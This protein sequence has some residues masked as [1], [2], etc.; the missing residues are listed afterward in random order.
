MPIHTIVDT[1]PL[2]PKTRRDRMKARLRMAV[3]VAP[4]T[5]VLARQT[6]RLRMSRSQA[7]RENALRAVR[8]PI[9]AGSVFGRLV[10]KQR[11]VK[12]GVVN[13]SVRGQVQALFGNARQNAFLAAKRA[14]LGDRMEAMRHAKAAAKQ[15]A[16]GRRL[17][18]ELVR[19][20]A[21]QAKAEG[22][23]LIA[24]SAAMLE[25]SGRG[26]VAV[27]L[28]RAA[29]KL[30]ATP[31]AEPL[32]A[33]LAVPSRPERI[34]G[35]VNSFTPSAIGS[36][37]V[38]SGLGLG[39]YENP[40][41]AAAASAYVVSGLEDF[42]N[43]VNAATTRIG[44][45]AING[46]A[47]AERRVRGILSWSGLSGLGQF[48]AR[49]AAVGAAQTGGAVAGGAVAGPVGAAVGSTLAAETPGL[50]QRGL[51]ALFGKRPKKKKK[52]KKVSVAASGVTEAPT[53]PK[54]LGLDPPVAIGLGIAGAAV[55]ALGGMVFTGRRRRR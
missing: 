41:E 44:N 20:K 28:R 42:D 40:V 46:A 4:F 26:D 47:N 54:I 35:V 53:P 18:A 15:V 51:D 22:Q 7:S 10:N 45:A 11:A 9:V 3:P 13:R 52:K 2:Q 55:L 8:R 48:G 23:A 14:R 32:P 38:I 43:E 5:S 12:L 16:A 39:Q 24:S 33:D 19:G 6:Q 29:E 17:C 36:E 50:V 34:V 25:A 49:S 27:Q 31:V 1:E 30:A 37:Y 21:A